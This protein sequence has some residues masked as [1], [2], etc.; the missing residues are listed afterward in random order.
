LQIALA[1][2]LVFEEWGWRPLADRLGRLARWGPW[3]QLEYGIARLPPY[4]A[5]FVFALPSLLLLPLKFLAVFLV[6]RGQIALA[7]ILFAGA[8]VFATAL[9]AR[10]FMLTQP[11]LM[12]IGWFAWGYETFMPWKEALVDRVR[13][14]YV[15]RMGRLIKERIRRAAMARWRAL[16][17]TLLEMRALIHAVA[18]RLGAQLH[19][20]LQDIRARRATPQ[21]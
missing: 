14:S 13:A 20:A 9:V 7:A 11:A 4:A 12:Q 21:R 17:P 15:W 2:L 18:V 6:A 16:R 3:A 5:L 19:R 8:K 10:L 1:L